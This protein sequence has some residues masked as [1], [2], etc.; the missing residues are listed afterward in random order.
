M[1]VMLPGEALTLVT[2]AGP[3]MP[4]RRVEPGKEVLLGRSSECDMRLEDASV[5]RR[6]ARVKPIGGRWFL[7]DLGSRHGTAVNGLR[8]RTEEPM[9]LRGGDHITIG[10]WTL[11]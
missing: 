7:T 4:P 10:P 2:L 5:S 11:R 3:A 9:P 6:H 8:V 1:T